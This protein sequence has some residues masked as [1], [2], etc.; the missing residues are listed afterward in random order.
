MYIM[1]IYVWM[2]VYDF[3]FECSFLDAQGLKKTSK[4]DFSDQIAKVQRF[5]LLRNRAKLFPTLVVVQGLSVVCV[6]MNFK[7]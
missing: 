2:Y 3:R 5:F 6:D 1:Y 4:G 7:A